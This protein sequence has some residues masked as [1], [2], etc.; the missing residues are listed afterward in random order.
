MYKREGYMPD[1]LISKLKFAAMQ[2]QMTVLT[3]EEASA[4][5]LHIEMLSTRVEDKQ[6][7]F[8]AMCDHAYNLVQINRD[9]KKR[10]GEL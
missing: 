5:Y 7:K 3:P 10:L 4:I 1:K 8:V 2:N 6:A 9:L